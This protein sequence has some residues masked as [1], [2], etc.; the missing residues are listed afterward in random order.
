MLWSAKERTPR[1]G[2]SGQSAEARRRRSW[3]V[4]PTPSNAT[5]AMPRAVDHATRWAESPVAHAVL[6]ARPARVRSVGVADGES[7]QLPGIGAPG[8]FGPLEV[9]AMRGPAT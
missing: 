5:A 4:T 8:R 7:A 3:V 6:L 1:Y 2:V 9:G